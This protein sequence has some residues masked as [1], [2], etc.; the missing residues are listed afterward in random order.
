MKHKLPPTLLISLIVIICS[1]SSPAQNSSLPQP[2]NLSIDTINSMATWQDPGVNS[3]ILYPQLLGYLVYLDDSLVNE[4]SDTSYSFPY[5]IYGQE[6]ELGVAAKYSCGNSDK[7]IIDFTSAFLPYPRNLTGEPFDNAII[8]EWDYPYC[9]SG[10][11]YSSFNSDTIPPGLIGYNIYRDGDSVGS[12]SDSLNSY[13]DFNL[14]PGWTKHKVTAL[15]DLSFYGYSGIKESNPSNEAESFISLYCP[16]PFIEDWQ[17]GNFDVNEWSHNDC[18]NWKVLADEGNPWPAAAFTQDTIIQNYS[19]SIITYPQMGFEIEDGN[20]YLEFDLKLNDINASGTENFN[21]SIIQRRDTSYIIDEITNNGSFDWTYYLYDISQWAK[22]FDF[23]IAFTANGVNNENI[24]SWLLD[25]IHI[26]V[27]CQPPLNL[28]SAL[29][30]LPDEMYSYLVWEP[31]VIIKNNKSEEIIGYNIFR[32]I[33]GLNDDFEIINEEIVYDTTYS[34]FDLITEGIYS[35]AVSAVYD[36]CVSYLSD[37]SMLDIVFTGIGKQSESELSLFPNPADKE[38]NMNCTEIVKAIK[39]YY[40]NGE[41]TI[42]QSNINRNWINMNTSGWKEGVYLI[43]IQT[44]KGFIN[45]KLTI[46][47]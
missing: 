5:L 28:Q 22:G 37:S 40:L 8:L 3:K 29:I 20:I 6:Y 26:Y 24:E 18:D 12:V 27:V 46:K 39:I 47:H 45:T 35:Y 44:A 32:K 4:T 10:L 34:D 21:I 31:P 11:F 16:L 23:R 36:Q 7:S 1:T 42:I 13:W 15:Y 33:E 19:C 30:D 38:V 25:N 17:Y 41:L 43:K 9:N 14:L 2:Q